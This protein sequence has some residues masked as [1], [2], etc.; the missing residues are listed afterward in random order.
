MASFSLA[1]RGRAKTVQARQ[2][3]TERRLVTPDPRQQ[4]VEQRRREA[5]VQVAFGAHD[6]DHPT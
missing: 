5:L 3:P 6:F 1:P 4:R 2:G